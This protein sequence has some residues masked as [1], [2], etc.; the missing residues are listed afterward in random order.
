MSIVKLGERLLAKAVPT[1]EADANCGRCSRSW[2]NQ[3][4]RRYYRK[5][6]LTDVC[7]N[8]CGYGCDYVEKYCS[9]Y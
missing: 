4:C 5:Y 3:C 2:S 1:V 6:N 8:Y 9:N 7:G